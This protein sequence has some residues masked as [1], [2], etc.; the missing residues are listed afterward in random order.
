MPY[1]WENECLQKYGEEITA[2]LVK[3]QKQYEKEHEGNNC[4]NCGTGNEGSIVVLED[5]TPHLMH[6]GL[7]PDECCAYCGRHQYE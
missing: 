3:Q 1:S 5:G 6:F 2:N 4:H 7:W